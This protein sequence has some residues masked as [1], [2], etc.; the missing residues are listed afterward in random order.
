MNDNPEVT[1]YGLSMMTEMIKAIVA[2][3]TTEERYGII[4]EAQVVPPLLIRAFFDGFVVPSMALAQSGGWMNDVSIETLEVEAYSV[5]AATSAYEVGA[6]KETI[7]ESVG[8]AY[9]DTKDMFEKIEAVVQ[10]KG[11][12]K[13]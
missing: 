6:T 1:E 13:H 4:R 12:T 3:E 8:R 10:A 9:D 2:A 5:A 7:L 11:S